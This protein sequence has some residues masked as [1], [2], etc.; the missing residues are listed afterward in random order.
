MKTI[1]Y[2]GSKKNLIPNLLKTVKGISSKGA[3]FD[4]FSGSG[5]VAYALK[6]TYKVIAN[7]KQAITKAIL[8]CYM[9]NTQDSSYY[10]PYIQHLNSLDGF[11]GWFSEMYSIDT[12]DYSVDKYGNPKLWQPHVAN[13]VDAIR[14]EIDKIANNEIEKSTL[15]TALVLACSKVSNTL[16]HQNGYLKKWAKCTYNPLM[17]EVP[18]VQPTKTKHIIHNSDVFSIIDSVACDIAYFDPPYGT[19]NQNLSVS[20]R[21]SSFYHVWNTIVKNDKP[22]TF[23]KANKPLYTKGFTEPLEKNKIDIV[24]P[25]FLDLIKRV[26]TDNVLFSYS[27]QGLL[28]WTDFLDISSAL[29]CAEIAKTEIPHKKNNQS[30]TALKDGLF[31]SDAKTREPLCEW[32][33]TI[34]K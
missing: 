33:I 23:G 20:T 14:L 34:K 8:D 17:L 15:L 29:H 5:R 28:K 27:N 4:V 25:L 32:L 11:Y 10:V 30:K 12:K 22:A 19:S 9:C 24:K 7:D 13:K 3:F 21:Y 1:Q 31:I 6:D 2:M 18:E 16:G 26:Q